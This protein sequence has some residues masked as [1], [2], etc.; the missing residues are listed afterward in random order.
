MQ[1]RLVFLI[2]FSR[3]DHDTLRCVVYVYFYR[4]TVSSGRHAHLVAL[5]RSLRIRRTATFVSFSFRRERKNKKKNEG[6]GKTM[7]QSRRQQATSLIVEF[8]EG[9]RVPVMP[10]DSSSAATEMHI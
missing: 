1:I 2:L 6:E 10:E 8:R 3:A 9:G 7:R 4:F 5:C